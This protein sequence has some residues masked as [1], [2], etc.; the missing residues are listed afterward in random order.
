LS[1]SRRY[2]KGKLCL[3][4]TYWCDADNKWPEE[5]V[6]GEVIEAEDEIAASKVELS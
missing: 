5:K 4:G 6:Q 1:G 3:W 2:R